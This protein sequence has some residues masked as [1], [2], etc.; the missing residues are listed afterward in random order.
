MGRER[1]RWEL[2][3]DFF[4]LLKFHNHVAL[5]HKYTKGTRFKDHKKE[6]C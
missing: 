2:S 3:E 6:I 1:W 4:F 5:K